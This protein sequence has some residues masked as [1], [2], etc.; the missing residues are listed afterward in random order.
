MKNWIAI[1]LVALAA[2]CSSGG[3]TNP[4]LS[5]SARSGALST[6]AT[7]TVP[8]ATGVS[9]TRIRVALRDLELRSRDGKSRAE[10]A[11]GPVV[12]D[13]GAADLS[14]A[15]VQKVLD[16]TVPA[17]TYDKIKLKIHRLQSADNVPGADDLVKAGASILIDGTFNGTAFQFATSLE[18]EQELEGKFVIDGQSQ[19]ITIDFDSSAW[20]TSGTTV[21]DP[22]DP[23][24]K[25]AIEA[26][27]RASLNAFQDD[28][29]IGHEN[30]HGDD[31][32]A[33]HDAGDDK[34]ND[35]GD[36]KGG[37]AAGAGTGTADDHGGHGNDDGSG[38]H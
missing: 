20:F 10:I 3:G 19:N 8:S 28:D 26:N 29:G 1:P 9:L 11:L 23:A 21:L 35:A 2:A 6:A 14:S 22:S 25:L 30:H 12:V 5:V 13:L 32:A 7:T 27:I 38:H 31:D 4:S 24:N 34:G 15:S 16:S 17:G 36:D 37:A 18:A 33:N